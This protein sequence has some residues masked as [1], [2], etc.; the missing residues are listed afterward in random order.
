MPDVFCAAALTAASAAVRLWQIG[1]VDRVVWD[2]AH[3]GRF[4][5]MYLNGTYIHDVHPPLGKLL[6]ALAECIAVTDRSFAFPSGAQYPSDGVNHALLRSLVALWGILLPPLAYATIRAIGCRRSAALMAAWFVLFDNALS[7]MTRIV[8]LD[9]PLLCFTA[10]TLAATAHWLRTG[11]TR[12]MATAGVSLGLTISVKWVGLFSVLLVGILTAVD[13]IHRL[14]SANRSRRM[15]IYPASAIW[16][17]R[18]LRLIAIRALLLIVLP[19]CVYI[20]VFRIHFALQTENGLGGDKMPIRFQANLRYNKYN[21]QPT[22]IA[23]NGSIA[24]LWPDGY[25][26]QDGKLL[27][28]RPDLHSLGFKHNKRLLTDPQRVGYGR[29]LTGADWW[30]FKPVDDDLRTDVDRVGDRFVCDGCS[31]RLVHDTTRM[32]LLLDHRLEGNSDYPVIIAKPSGSANYSAAGNPTAIDSFWIVEIVSQEVRSL[33][34]GLLHPISTSFRL[35]HASKR[36]TLTLALSPRSQTQNHTAV[37]CTHRLNRP[38]RWRIEYHV[39][40]IR[41]FENNL[42]G[43]VPTSFV[44]NFVA[45]NMIMAAANAGLTPQDP[46]R[47]DVLASAPWTWPF[48]LQPMRASIWSPLAVAQHSM[49]VYEVGNPLLWWASAVVCILMYPLRLAAACVRLKRSH[50]SYSKRSCVF[51]R[52]VQIECLQR[53][54]WGWMLWLGWALHY[55]PFFLMRRVTY[56]HH[57]LPALYFALLL[58]AVELDSVVIRR[59]NSRLLLPLILAAI[60]AVYYLFWPCTYGWRQKAVTDLAYLQVLPSWNIGGSLHDVAT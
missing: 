13:I 50:M 31:V 46:D 45:Q 54:P 56:L 16:M 58:L 26:D 22:N 21:R 11:Q 27:A 59:Y 5:S 30:G 48:L 60:A 4:G 2:E 36:C 23:Y 15:N 33:D 24:K 9:G 10:L 39:H 44:E 8:V 41:G 1:R 40:W 6:V 3:F 47:Y 43:M 57:Y 17:R 55:L 38:D 42:Q 52:A 28:F 25:N 35:R 34:D 49:V 20:A 7:L 37:V 53:H 32:P 51:G 12:W 29:V 19:L 18:L 14:L